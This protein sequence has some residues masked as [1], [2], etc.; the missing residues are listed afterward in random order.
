MQYVTCS[1]KILK[2]NITYQFSPNFLVLYFLWVFVVVVFGVG[3]TAHCDEIVKTLGLCF[4][5]KGSMCV[6]TLN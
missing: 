3:E 5:Y 4:L 6:M 1:N 2:R